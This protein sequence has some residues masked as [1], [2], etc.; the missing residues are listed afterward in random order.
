VSAATVTFAGIFKIKKRVFKKKETKKVL[1]P[2][3]GKPNSA[4]TKQTHTKG[5]KQQK[6]PKLSLKRKKPIK[7]HEIRN[8][9]AERSQM[10]SEEKKI[11]L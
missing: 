10:N 11:Y 6:D 4:D 8:K 3:D 7:S 1:M 2:R 9:R 5:E